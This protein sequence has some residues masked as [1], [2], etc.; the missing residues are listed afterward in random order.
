MLFENKLRGCDQHGCGHWGAPR[1]NV[2]HKGL[3]VA[4]HSGQKVLSPVDGIV[5]K[6]G[7]AYSKMYLSKNH[8]R[9]VE[10]EVNE[11]VRIRIFYIEPFV[12]TGHTV[13]KGQW[14][15]SQQALGGIYGGITEHI[16]IEFWDNGKRKNPIGFFNEFCLT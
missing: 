16:H 15:G 8:Y 4:C 10:I 1:G 2:K 3:D 12:A 11:N 13:L 14:I 6:V 9:F 5:T 7:F